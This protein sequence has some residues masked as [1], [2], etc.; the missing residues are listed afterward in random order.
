MVDRLILLHSDRGRAVDGIRDHSRFLAQELSRRSIQVRM[1]APQGGPNGAGAAAWA[2]AIYR[3]RGAG[4]GSAVVLQYMPFCF[5]RWG[6]APWLPLYLLALR[7]Q[8]R[9][10]TIAIVVH[11]PYVPM[12]SWQWVLMGL[13]Q[14]LQ[15]FAL[16]A[17]A[18]VLFTSIDLWARTLEKPPPRRPVQR[19]PVG[20]NFPDR[21][22]KRD[23]ARVRLGFDEGTIVLAT[24]GRDHPVWRREY[25][26]AAVNAIAESGRAV[27]L[28]SLG[29]EAPELV[30][31]D[32]AVAVHRPGYLEDD[33][34]AENLAAADMFLA[35]LLDGVSTKRGTLMAAL[36]HGLPVVGTVG[37]MTDPILRD[38]REALRLTEVRDP[39]SFADSAVQL[40]EDEVARMSAATAA[41]QLYES[42]FSWPVIASELIEALP[43]GRGYLEG[44]S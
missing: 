38:S 18:D 10:P 1:G 2:R 22:S 11:E 7:L 8:S 28:L 16:R 4:P 43:D 5:A 25:V 31:L 20:S 39:D 15:L 23:D 3:L 35:P 40:A 26:V 6:F 9:R 30:G 44:S 42:H 32:A 29:G 37:P 21:R 17:T 41:R 14:R 13:W 19:L 12:I 33:E 36:Q 24:I 34:L 27:E